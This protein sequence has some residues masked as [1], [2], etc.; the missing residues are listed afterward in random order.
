[1]TKITDEH[2]VVVVGAG[3]AGIAATRRLIEA[4]VD[5]LLLEARNRVGGRALS[6]RQ[7]NGAA[8]DLGCGWLH[9]ADVNPWTDIATA[10]GF[11]IDRTLPPWQDE[12]HDLGM[13]LAQRRGLHVHRST[14]SPPTHRQL[15]S[16][17]HKS[18]S[19]ATGAVALSETTVV[20]R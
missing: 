7:G 13:S 10:L 12:K 17:E 8:I 15:G 18:W 9:S 16:A 20:C 6:V 1:V 11:E 3:A 2:D 19:D 5:V 4:G 14:V